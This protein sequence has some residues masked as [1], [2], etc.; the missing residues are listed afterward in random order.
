MV[1]GYHNFQNPPYKASRQLLIAR[2][3][4]AGTSLN[5]LPCHAWQGYW[6]TSAHRE[7]VEGGVDG[8][9]SAPPSGAAAATPPAVGGFVCLGSKPRGYNILWQD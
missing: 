2:I 7:E 4:T 3:A 9:A 6:V 5:P 8:L 1:Y